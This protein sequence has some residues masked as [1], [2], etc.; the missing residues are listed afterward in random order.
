M[1]TRNGRTHACGPNTGED[2]AVLAVKVACFAS[3]EDV[4]RGRFS[5][6]A[7][8]KDVTTGRSELWSVDDS[9]LGD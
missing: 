5:D 2:A 9:G 8:G 7:N 6:R 4:G 3:I 1:G